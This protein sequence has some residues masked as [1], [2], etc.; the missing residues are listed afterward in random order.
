MLPWCAGRE[1]ANAAIEE[2]AQLVQRVTE[3]A[4]ASWP[5][6]QS[7]CGAATREDALPP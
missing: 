4:A 2:A 1:A 3:Q 5:E 6:M 7:L